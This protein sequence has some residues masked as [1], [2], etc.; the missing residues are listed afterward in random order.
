MVINKKPINYLA[1]TGGSPGNEN[2]FT[3]EVF[4]ED[5]V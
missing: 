3:S 4:G 5:G 2:N 1:D